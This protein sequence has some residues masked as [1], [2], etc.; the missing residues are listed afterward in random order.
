MEIESLLR[1]WQ[2][3][4][5]GLATGLFGSGALIGWWVR[6]RLRR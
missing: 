2:W 6:G 3:E 1:G 5:L 4:L